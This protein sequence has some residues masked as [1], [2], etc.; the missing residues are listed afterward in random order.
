MPTFRGD[1]IEDAEAEE[2]A[3]KQNALRWPDF[4]EDEVSAVSTVLK[5]GR[6]NY[7]TGSEVKTFESEYAKFLV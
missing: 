3:L 6:V 4:S 2:T 1:K 5:S 7:W